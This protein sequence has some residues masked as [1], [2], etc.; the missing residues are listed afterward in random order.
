LRPGGA[1][2]VRGEVGPMRPYVPSG[3]YL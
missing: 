3:A 1:T 2:C